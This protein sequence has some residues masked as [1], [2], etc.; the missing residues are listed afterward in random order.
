MIDAYLPRGIN[1]IIFPRGIFHSKQGGGNGGK[2]KHS[3]KSSGRTGKAGSSKKDKGKQKASGG[4]PATAGNAGSSSK[5]KG[6]ASGDRTASTGNAGSSSKGKKDGG[7]EKWYE[8]TPLLRKTAT[9][10]RFN[11]VDGWGC[12]I[13]AQQ[14]EYKVLEK[15]KPTIKFDVIEVKSGNLQ[16]VGNPTDGS[17]PEDFASKRGNYLLTNAG[18]FTM[19]KTH[20]SVGPTSSTRKMV[21]I[22]PEYKEYYEKVTGEDGSYLWSGPSLT[23]NLDLLNGDEFNFFDP[24][25]SNMYGSLA[26]A[27]QPNERLVLVKLKNGDKY[28]FVYTADKPRRSESKGGGIHPGNGQ[29][30]NEMRELILFWFVQFKPEVRASS[31]TQ[32]V[33]LDGG[34]SLYVSWNERGKRER[35]IAR[36][37]IEDETPHGVIKNHKEEVID[38][39]TPTNLIKISA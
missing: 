36:G 33:N 18:F 14:R 26:H 1:E 22:P 20:R 29:T 35:K 21:P 19:D 24:N 25:Y 12:K 9:W 16:I 17:P 7:A 34:G 13:P 3:G 6:K 5:G 31:M 4:T 39:R 15:M 32:F 30:I 10:W 38:I 28:M 23:R 11:S 27:G 37:S 8:E 2:K